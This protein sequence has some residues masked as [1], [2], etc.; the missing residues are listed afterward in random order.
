GIRKHLS[1]Q[2]DFRPHY[3][4]SFLSGSYAR[5]T[6]IRPRTADGQ[7]EKPDVDI[8]VV[9]NFTEHDAP[10]DVLRTVCKAL[11]DG[12]SGY[13]VERMNRRSVRVETWQADMDVVPVFELS[14]G[15]YMIAD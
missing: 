4:D 14:T 12:G 6:S 15:G 10:H 5:D 2:K 13:P 7:T 8:I 3:V 11:E 9:T 1:G